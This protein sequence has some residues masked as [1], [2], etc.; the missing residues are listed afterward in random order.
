MQALSRKH[1]PH[2]ASG[3]QYVSFVAFSTGDC[4]HLIKPY[5]EW[6]LDV[7]IPSRNADLILYRTRFILAAN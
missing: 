4:T 1:N 3:M 5:P 6:N 2:F 7:R